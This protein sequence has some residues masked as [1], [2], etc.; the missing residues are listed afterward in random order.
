M[1]ALD[2]LYFVRSELFLCFAILAILVLDFFVREKK[3]L[4]W[5]SFTFIVIAFVIPSPFY[6]DEGLF[7]DSYVWD[8][9]TFFFRAVVY[10]T[11]GLTILASLA[12]E[13]IPERAQS[14]F[15]ILLLTTAVLLTL[16]GGVTNLLMVFLT[17]E[18]VSLTSFL[19][20]GFQKFDKA[21]SEASLKYVLFG[22]ISSATMLFG[23]SLLFGITGTIDLVKMGEILLLSTNHAIQTMGLI[24][25][26][27]LLVGIGFKIS[28][29]PFHMWAP[30]VYQGAPTPVA[31]FLTVA[32]KALGFAVLAR[33]FLSAFPNLVPKWTLLLQLLAVVTMTVGNIIAISQTDVKRLLAY[34]S[35]AQAGYILVGF[36]LPNELG[37]QAVLIYI[38][39]Y[40]FTNLGAFFTVVAIER[41]LGSNQLEMYNGLAIRSPLLALAL[42]LFL[43]SL[44][45]IPPLAGFIAKVYIF[46]AAISANAI[47]L[48]IAIALNS[49]VA[50]YYYF[51]VVRAMYL[52]P[53]LASEKLKNPFSIKIAVV[54]SLLGL[55]LIGLWPAPLI[56]MVEQ[57]IVTLPIF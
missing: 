24:G 11:V 9:F 12:Y 41:N 6:P 20:V 53:P 30:D 51:K 18:S 47:A 19:L 39:A 16:M 36:V 8:P 38:V 27:L 46:S 31:G 22:A 35:I 2:S 15:Y 1:D 4:G 21:S 48:A 14:E 42:T 44:T 26:T 56:R 23:M 25:M 13:K 37:L 28:V 45:G 50:A 7:F 54:A 52:V 40:L 10:G 43:L 55:F 49:A 29:V 57:S 32:P 33:V 5:L 17:I 34:S 3:W